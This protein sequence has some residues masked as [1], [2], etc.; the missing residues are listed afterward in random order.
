MTFESSL[1]CKE[2]KSVNPKG[3][4]S[5]ILIGGTDAESEMPVIWPPDVKNW[6]T[7]KDPDAGN[8]WKQEEKGVTEAEMAVW[9][10]WL[11]GHEF[12]Q[13]VGVG[14][15]PREAR[16]A[17]VH[18]VGH[19][20]TTE[21]NEWMG[22]QVSLVQW[23][24]P[25]STCDSKLNVVLELL[26]SPIKGWK[27]VAHRWCFQTPGLHRARA[28]PLTFHCLALSSWESHCDQAVKLLGD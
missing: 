2:I 12:E 26:H 9:H 25:S 22:T 19:D 5:W 13:A 11:D 28:L 27:L 17:A 21:M 7:G 1:D 16:G 8:D 18:G 10:H 20:W 15:G 4:Q 14:D 6:L 24:F 3:N 23:P